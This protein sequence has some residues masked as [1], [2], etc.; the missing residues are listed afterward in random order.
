MKTVGPRL[1]LKGTKSLQSQKSQLHWR[2][3]LQAKVMVLPRHI[4]MGIV[5]TNRCLVASQSASS[6]CSL[7]LMMT[8]KLTT[9]LRGNDNCSFNSF[10][11]MVTPLF[12]FD[13]T[14]LN[15]FFY[16]SHNWSKCLKNFHLGRREEIVSLQNRDWFLNLLNWHHLLSKNKGL[17][18]RSF[19]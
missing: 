13:F 9:K 5:F 11:L 7:F 15:S 4:H 19:T 12:H 8:L 2:R 18:S 17:P 3:T 14:G 16:R 10:N 6:S 1:C